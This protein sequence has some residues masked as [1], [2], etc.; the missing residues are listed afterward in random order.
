MQYGL[1][2][3]TMDDIARK[4]GVSK[5]TIYQFFKD[6][7]DIIKSAIK[8]HFEEHKQNILEATNSTKTATEA[9]IELSSCMKRQVETINPAVL[10]DLQKYYPKSY[11]KVVEFKQDF[12]LD[13][14]INML[15]KGIADGSFRKEI[16]VEILA[17]LR[18]EQVQFA[19]NPTV[20]PR[21]KFDFKTVNFQMFEHFVHGILTEKGRE[22]YSNLISKNEL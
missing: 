16:N 2:S 22:Q 8:D 7:N 19:F 12:M 3:V 9:L 17:I 21:D 4:S 10:Y 11:Q 1:K 6:K 15:N 5:K 18:I 20:F 13:L 14:V